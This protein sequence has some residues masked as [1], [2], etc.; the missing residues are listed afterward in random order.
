M[1]ELKPARIFLGLGSNM[2][3]REHN[4]E[5]ALQA[6]SQKIGL[7]KLSSL[8]D[9]A[10]VGNLLQKRFLNMACQGET[11]L[12]PVALL[13]FIKEIEHQL[14]R[15]PGPVNSPRPID[16]DVLFYNNLIINMPELVIPHPRLVE[17]AFVLAPL[18]EIAPQ[19]IHPITKQKVS[20]LLKLLKI[21]PGDAVK[22]GKIRGVICTK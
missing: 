5:M 11:A 19:F 16:I 14:G 3:D 21:N 20:Q 2:G 15:Q 10:P 8:Y 9:T 7:V 12:T 18:N 13:A 4:M 6:L 1:A 17:R 22:Q